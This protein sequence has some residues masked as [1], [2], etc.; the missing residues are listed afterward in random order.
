MFVS[1]FPYRRLS[2]EIIYS[3]NCMRSESHCSL[4]ILKGGFLIFLEKPPFLLMLGCFAKERLADVKDPTAD[5]FNLY[6]GL[7]L[8]LEGFLLCKKRLRELVYAFVKLF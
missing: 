8:L 3:L 7:V 6:L 1:R 5:R 2:V 4:Y